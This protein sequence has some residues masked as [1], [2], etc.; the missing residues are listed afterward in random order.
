MMTDTDLIAGLDL[1]GTTFWEFRDPG[2]KDKIRRIAKYPRSTQYSEVNISPMWLQWLRHTRSAAPT[3]A[4]QEADTQ[5]QVDLKQLARLA[6]ERW[7]SKQ[8]YIDNPKD[9][10]QTSPL[11]APNDTGGYRKGEE[12]KPFK[13]SRSPREEWQPESW[14]PGSAQR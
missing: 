8:S 13:P 2:N 4:E 5:R 3:I 11:I 6:D 12:P 14:K 10:A 7:N 9:T 1:S